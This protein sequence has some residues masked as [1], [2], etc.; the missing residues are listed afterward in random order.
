[1]WPTRYK[2][3]DES[4][5]GTILHGHGCSTVFAVRARYR[6]DSRKVFEALASW[7]LLRDIEPRHTHFI[8]GNWKMCI[9]RAMFE[10]FQL[11]KGFRLGKNEWS[12]QR[13]VRDV[14]QNFEHL[15]V[16]HLEGTNEDQIKKM[17]RYLKVTMQ[18]S[19]EIILPPH[20]Q[21]CHLCRTTNGM[22][23]DEPGWRRLSRD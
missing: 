22:A 20:R 9:V 1:M 6:N 11:I 5:Q 14:E 3:L 2:G 4:P 18:A 15:K 13:H 12:R 10:I 17:P 21:I 7:F 16:T 23:S 19:R 8:V